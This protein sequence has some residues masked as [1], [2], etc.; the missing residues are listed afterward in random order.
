MTNEFCQSLKEVYEIIKLSDSEV[1]NKIPYKF[2]RYVYKNMDNTYDVKIDI[3]KSL[4][5]QEGISETTRSIL[6]LIYRDYLVDSKQS[7]ELKKEELKIATKVEEKKREKFD[8]RELFQK[9]NIEE[10]YN[11]DV[12]D[13]KNKNENM[14]LVEFKESLIKKIYSKLKSLIR[15]K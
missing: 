5:E 3:N 13:I 11:Q 7:E 8:T 2:K 1:R 12:Q 15:R 6:A 4:T 10:A 14:M 9:I